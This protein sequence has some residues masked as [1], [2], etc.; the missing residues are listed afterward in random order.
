MRDLNVLAEQ[1]R[2]NEQVCRR[3]Q[4]KKNVGRLHELGRCTARMRLNA[5]RSSAQVTQARAAKIREDRI[6]AVRGWAHATRR[7]LAVTLP[8]ELRAPPQDVHDDRDLV[9][10]TDVGVTV[11]ERPL[12][13][14]VDLRL[15]RE[16]LAIVGPSGAGKTTLLQVLV[17]ARRPTRGDATCLAGQVGHIDQDASGWISDDSLTERLLACSQAATLTEVAATLVA[18]K[19]PLALAERP[20]RSLSPGERVRAALICL[21]QRSP[22]P[23]LLVL[24]EPGDGLDVVGVLA[25]RRA[26]RAWTGGLIVASHDSDLLA[27][28]GVDRWLVLDGRGGHRTT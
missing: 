15:R 28:I 3:R 5:K 17:G 12:F 9:T 14:G 19:F 27:D 25:L 13:A 20:L 22:R 10:L 1:E 26:L 24:D 2:R 4:R 23:S 7:A 6:A 16:R 11:G 18:H 21:F 8:L